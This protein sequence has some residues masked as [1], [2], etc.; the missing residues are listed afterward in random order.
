M[1]TIVLGADDYGISPAVSAGIRELLSSGALTATSC[2]TVFDEWSDEG[3]LLREVDA[4]LGVH[5]TLTDAEPLTDLAAP[6]RE[7]RRM[8][9]FP[10]LLRLAWRGGLP[11]DAVEAELRAQI[12]AFIAVVGHAPDYLDGHQHIQQLPG[13]RDVVVRL[14]A[15]FLPDGYV[16]TCRE[17]PATALARWEST[18][19]ALGFALAARSLSS[20]LTRAGIRQNDGFTGAYDLSTEVPYAQR[21]ERFLGGVRDGSFFMCHPGRTDDLLRQRDPVVAARELELAWLGSEACAALLQRSGVQLGRLPGRV[22]NRRLPP[23]H[24]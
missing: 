3:L 24:V 7:G 8:L 23:G 6:L 18:P 1:P 10:R 15:E 4:D 20:S 2:M 17:R 12:E 11:T 14:A 13:V 5:L 22:P 19:R 9:S 21:F 16:R